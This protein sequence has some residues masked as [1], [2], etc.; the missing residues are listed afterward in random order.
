MKH[1]Y[2]SLNDLKYMHESLKYRKSVIKNPNAHVNNK[3]ILVTRK[4]DDW[5]YIHS[6][7]KVKPIKMH[8]KDRVAKYL[9]AD[10]YNSIKPNIRYI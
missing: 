9:L 5:N 4:P 6:I 10:T 3:C 8:Q 2:D 1:E 7:N